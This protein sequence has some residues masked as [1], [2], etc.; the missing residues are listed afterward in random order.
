MPST[1]RVTVGYSSL[2]KRKR[3]LKEPDKHPFPNT[4]STVLRVIESAEERKQGEPW[5]SGV[6]ECSHSSET[7]SPF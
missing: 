3:Q 2:V 5:G 7:S 1:Y 4:A 6:P